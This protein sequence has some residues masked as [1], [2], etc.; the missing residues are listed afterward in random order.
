MSG[1]PFSQLP[2]E[3]SLTDV[4]TAHKK[5]INLNLACHHI[6]TIQSF[7]ATKQTA[8][9]TLNYQQTFYVKNA[10]SGVYEQSLRPYPL[11]QDCPVVCLGGA[12]GALTFPITKGD[13]CLV[14][15]NDRDID[16][17]FAGGAGTGP[18]TPRLHSFSDALVIVGVRSL[19]KVLQA[20]D[21]TRV[22]LKNGEAKVGL[23]ES[24]IKISN[25]EHTLNDLLQDLVSKIQDLVTAT[26]AITVICSTPGNASSP[27]VNVA[28]ITAVGTQLATVATQIG[29]LLE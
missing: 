20:Y 6:G 9:V 24:L 22:V 5:D 11:L 16:N 17:W 4:L 10:A 28:A 13:E 12:A 25:D 14:L 19:G 26:S 27:P 7:D 2:A 23:T 1:L 18:A 29:E 15:F 3:P 21:T 8:T